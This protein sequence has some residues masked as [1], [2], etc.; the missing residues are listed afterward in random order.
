MSRAQNFH[1]SAIQRL[2]SPYIIWIIF[3]L[4]VSCGMPFI[5]ISWIIPKQGGGEARGRLNL[6]P[7]STV[8]AMKGLR[9]RFCCCRHPTASPRA[10]NNTNNSRQTAGAV[11]ALLLLLHCCCLSSSIRWNDWSWHQEAVTSST[12]FHCLWFICS[13]CGC[14][15][16][17]SEM[18]NTKWQH[19]MIGEDSLFLKTLINTLCLMMGST[20]L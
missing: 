2:S 16:C 5:K 8:V 10:L 13:L 3:T 20:M 7:V 19:Q 6:F 9:Y 4:H 14:I 1:H 17:Q 12:V 18:T 11:V 15:Q